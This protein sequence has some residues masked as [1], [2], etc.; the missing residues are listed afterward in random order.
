MHLRFDDEEFSLSHTLI[1]G[2]INLDPAA[3]LTLD[4]IAELASDY[5]ESGATFVELSVCKYVEKTCTVEEEIDMLCAALEVIKGCDLIPAVYTCDPAIMERVHECG[6][7]IIVDPLAL[8]APGALETASRLKLVVCLLM[9]QNVDFK[10]DDDVD[11]CG[12]V[13]EFFYERLDACMNA[14]IS[15]DRIILDPM[16]SVKT[17]VDYRLKMF[18]RLKT[19][20]SFGVP[21]SCSLPRLV[22]EGQSNP[23]QNMAMVSAVA[24]FAEQQGVRIIRTNKVYDIALSI[25]TWHALNQ[26]ARP[27]KLSR[28][29]GQRLKDMAARKKQGDRK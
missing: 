18:G 24:L 3:P 22:A 9:D 12:T 16:I 23:N 21:L 10:E 17:S 15:R 13:S 6:A 14:K 29:I 19:F 2:N 8:R 1:M 20:K 11:P 27:F 26:S 28:A 25:N 7:K 4:E 5:Q